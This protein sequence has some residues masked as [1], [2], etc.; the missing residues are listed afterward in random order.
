[1]HT[2]S[3]SL[4]AI[5]AWQFIYRVKTHPEFLQCLKS[6]VHRSS[7]R[8]ESPSST[9]YD[10]VS[11]HRTR[12]PRCESRVSLCDAPPTR[13]SNI[14]IFERKPKRRSPGLGSPEHR[15]HERQH[16]LKHSQRASSTLKHR[17]SPE[18][19]EQARL[20]SLES[21]RPQ[22][23]ARPDAPTD[24]R[25]A[26][27]RARPT[28]QSVSHRLRALRGHQSLFRATFASRSIFS[29]HS[30]HS[31]VLAKPRFAFQAPQSPQVLDV[32]DSMARSV[33]MTLPSRN[34]A[35]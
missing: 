16:R 22:L 11:H 13:T 25:E 18:G 23:L 5:T 8:A 28:N 24:P 21:Q 2:G 19:E 32:P 17:S 15:T 30:R 6:N 26:R 20:E 7:Y 12:R 9:R 27:K 4:F 1:M 34:A 35:F 10:P 33:T 29:P 31:N 14:Y 3:E